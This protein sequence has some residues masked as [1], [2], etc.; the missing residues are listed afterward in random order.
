[1]QIL[2]Y[3]D[4]PQSTYQSSSNEIVAVHIL[5]HHEGMGQG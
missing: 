3:I 2:P 1:M 4:F 5:E